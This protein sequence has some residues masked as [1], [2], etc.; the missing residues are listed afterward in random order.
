MTDPTDAGP[1]TSEHIETTGEKIVLGDAKDPKPGN[2]FF[3]LRSREGYKDPEPTVELV[4][5]PGTESGTTVRHKYEPGTLIGP[6]RRTHRGLIGTMEKEDDGTQNGENDPYGY[7]CGGLSQPSAG[8]SWERK[9]H[10]SGTRR[11]GGPR[12]ADIRGAAW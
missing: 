6:V 7:H 5:M 1:G 3:S 12:S 4:G 9:L 11:E 8:G 10:N 2:Y